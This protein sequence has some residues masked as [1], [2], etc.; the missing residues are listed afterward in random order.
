M[1]KKKSREIITVDEFFTLRDMLSGNEE[2]AAVALE[3]YKNKYGLDQKILNRLMCKALNFEDRVKFSIA[4]KYSFEIGGRQFTTNP[5]DSDMITTRIFAYI[6]H[7][8]LDDIYKEILNKIS[9]KNKDDTNT[10]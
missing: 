1:K 10:R 3:I 5:L 2:D 6:D 8:K 9:N 4:V 7:Y